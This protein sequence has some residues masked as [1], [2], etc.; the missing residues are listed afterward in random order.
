VI[1]LFILLTYHMVE[2]NTSKNQQKWND[3]RRNNT[4]PWATE[5][6]FFQEN[7]QRSSQAVIQ[8]L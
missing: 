8:L 4:N 2:T 5:S 3:F 7:W 1:N 6:L